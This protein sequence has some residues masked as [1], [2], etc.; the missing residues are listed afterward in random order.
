MKTDNER[1]QEALVVVL[2]MLVGMVVVGL[3]AGIVLSV[4]KVL[5]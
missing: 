5:V 1:A 2:S 3:V 4:C